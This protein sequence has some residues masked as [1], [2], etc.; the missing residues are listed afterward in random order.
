MGEYLPHIN[1]CLFVVWMLWLLDGTQRTRKCTRLLLLL[2][3]C[4]VHGVT[5]NQQHRS[6]GGRA[7]CPSPSPVELQTTSSHTLIERRSWV[8]ARSPE[9]IPPCGR[10][11]HNIY[12]S[13]SRETQ[14]IPHLQIKRRMNLQIGVKKCANQ[15][16]MKK[17][18]LKLRIWCTRSQISGILNIAVLNYF[19]RNEACPK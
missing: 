16:T 6:S 10:F 18:K 11:P 9:A 7:L 3:S 4:V 19:C 1:N 14:G 15:T 5:S 2:D 8:L 17:S 12:K 13:L